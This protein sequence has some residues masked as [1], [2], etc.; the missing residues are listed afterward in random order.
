M[1]PRLVRS[2]LSSR[3][4]VLTR[5]KVTPGTRPGK[6]IL[7]ATGPRFDVTE[8]FEEV[9]KQMKRQRRGR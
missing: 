6:E 8:D 7:E 5:Y 1:T 9:V 2:P 3:V 4:Y